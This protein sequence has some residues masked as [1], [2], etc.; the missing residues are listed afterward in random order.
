MLH[1]FNRIAREKKTVNAMINL[2]CKDN[3]KNDSLCTDCTEL[4]DYAYQRL[5]NC[6]FAHEK[7]V[8]NKCTVHCYSR[9]KREKIRNIMRYAGPRMIKKHPILAVFHI[10]DSNIEPKILPRKVKKQ[11]F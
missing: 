4:R 7:P 3:H 5:D 9:E 2:Y 6:Y 1:L 10:W 8:C 11:N